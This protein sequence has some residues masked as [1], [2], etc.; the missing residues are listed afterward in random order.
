MPACRIDAAPPSH[1]HRIVPRGRTL[2]WWRKRS[3]GFEWRDYVRTTILVRREE[4]RQRIKDVQGAAKA[5]VKEAGRRGVDAAVAGGRAAATGS[6][7][8]LK[9]AG[10]ALKQAATWTGHAVGRA[11]VAAAGFIAVAGTTLLAGMG[12]AGAWLASLLRGAST[13]LAPVLEPVLSFVRQPR[14]HL[15]LAIVAVVAA[16]GAAYRSRAFGFDG[17]AKVATAV[18]IVVGLLVTLAALTDPDRRWHPREDSLIGRLRGYQLNLPGDRHIPVGTAAL[19][20]LALI[21]VSVIGVAA[22]GQLGRESDTGTRVAAAAPATSAKKPTTTA[23][24]PSTA[25]SA[26]PATLTSRRAQAVTG[27]TLKIGSTLVML[28]GIEAPEAGQSCERASG[29]WRCGRAARDALA[30]L[31]RGRSVSCKISENI[32]AGI[33]KGTC[34]IGGDTDLAEKLLEAGMVFAASSFFLNSYARIERNAQ[35]EKKGL[36]AGEPERPQEWRNRRWA[37]AKEKAPD[38]C[39]IKGR[40]RSGARTY[41]LPWSASYDGVRLSRARGERWFCSE[42][43]AQAAGWRRASS[44]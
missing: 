14:T 9:A 12:T 4:R 42:S 34:T 35:S 28:D 22:L 36:W 32:E 20:L 25:E 7:W 37:E 43:E 8:S 17:D 29:R 15:V 2:L 39:P 40:V 27:D 23:K 18:A 10:M 30:S 16:L 21:G 1:D 26:D 41:I 3:E 11:A 13:P 44:S 5:H 19:M 33:K 31:V 24:A 38:G 6:A